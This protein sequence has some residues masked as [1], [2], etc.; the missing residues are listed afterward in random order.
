MKSAQQPNDHA[1]PEREPTHKTRE[2]WQAVAEDEPA[3]AP[4]SE[5]A[6][7]PASEP[8]SEPARAPTHE[9]QKPDQEPFVP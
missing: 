8:A 1:H 2:H 5:P 6:I 4:A 9:P 7:E 3:R